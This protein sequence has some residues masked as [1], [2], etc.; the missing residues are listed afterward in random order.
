MGIN[1]YGSGL[2]G[3]ATQENGHLGCQPQST[4]A[5]LFQH[6]DPSLVNLDHGLSP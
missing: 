5:C 4:E 6:R 1:L 2:R 3:A